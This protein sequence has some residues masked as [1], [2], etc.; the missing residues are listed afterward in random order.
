MMQSRAD[1]FSL[2][3]SALDKLNVVITPEMKEQDVIGL[4]NSAKKNHINNYTEQTKYILTGTD[5][6]TKPKI[7]L[8]LKLS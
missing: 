4:Y 3:Q 6:V 1:G 5:I 2:D 8:N 7:K